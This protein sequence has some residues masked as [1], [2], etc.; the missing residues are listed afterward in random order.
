MIGV[1]AWYLRP[2]STPLCV[3]KIP[4]PWDGGESPNVGTMIALLCLSWPLGLAIQ[5]GAGLKRKCCAGHQLIVLRVR[6]GGSGS[7]TAIAVLYPAV[8]MVPVDP[9]GSM[10]IRPETLV[11]WHRADFVATGVGNLTHGEGDRRLIRTCV[12]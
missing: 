8:S 6:R 3:V 12:R 1:V 5:V 7:P 11:R 10:I 4:Y 2:W 9:E